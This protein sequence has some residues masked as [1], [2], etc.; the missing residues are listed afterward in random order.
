MLQVNKLSVSFGERQIFNDL[1]FVIGDGEK[2]GLAGG[3]GVGKTTI[4]RIIA[5]EIQPD[6]GDVKFSRNDAQSIGYVPQHLNI[7]QQD[8][9]MSVYEFMLEGRGLRRIRDDMTEI[10]RCLRESEGDKERL[11][12]AFLDLN[13]QYLTSEGYRADDDI[14]NLLLGLGL[15]DV[16]TDQQ[17]IT[18]SGGQKTRLVLAR[19]LFEQSDFLMLDEP[20]NHIDEEAVQWLSEY[21]AKSRQSMLI[22]SHVPSFLNQIVERILYLDAT[23]CQIKS[24]PG[25][26]T[27]FLTLRSRENKT[28]Q[29]QED[30]FVAEIERQ[31]KFI[32][33]APQSKTGLKHSREKIVK[34]LE[35]QLPVIQVKA[36]KEL[37]I[38]FPV[39]N[40]LRREAASALE[41]VKSF[42]S[43]KVLD[44]ITL[45][46]G[47]QDRLAVVGDNGTGK[48]T[49]LKI[50]AGEIEQDKGHV[51]RSR[52][53]ELGWY[54]QEQDDLQDDS[55]VYDE[56][57]GTGF[58]N[59]RVL[60]S[61]LAHFLFPADRLT[62]KVGTLSRGERARL[63][64]CKLMVRQ[65]NM[66]LLDEP[67]NH[68]DQPSRQSL[69]KALSKY[70]GAIVVVSHD[71]EFLLAINASWGIHLPDGRSVRIG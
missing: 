63:A 50:L 7:D 18:L 68:L 44:N 54:R 67:T 51:V 58:S 62:Q 15:E 69:V 26:Y 43:K 25:N 56:V 42:G 6:S 38:N 10:E 41:I 29:K 48:T 22:V 33:N 9:E 46:I 31:K 45:T 70:K 59:Q 39:R 17:V 4:L 23:T 47:S 8:K 37:D 12:E 13:D 36:A 55:L 60:R 57:A 20:T 19:M 65:P 27:R 49:L 24:Y 21:L 52:N 30:W 5:E 32:T 66:L 2:V 1:S 71:Y 3:N 64:L 16:D 14:L 35:K 40:P 11:S 61:I 53:L 34:K 28:A